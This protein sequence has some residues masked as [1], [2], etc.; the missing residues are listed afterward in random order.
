[1]A[2]LQFMREAFAANMRVPGTNELLSHAFR[3]PLRLNGRVKVGDPDAPNPARAPGAVLAKAA[4]RTAAWLGLED[5]ELTLALGVASVDQPLEPGS[6]AWYRALTL[7]HLGY[8]LERLCGDRTQAR[9]WMRGRNTSFGRPPVDMLA[10]PKGLDAL[11][12]HASG[13]TR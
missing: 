4:R 10:E 2:L 5:S 13:V 9:A 11:L 6:P 8:C 7:I 12:D 3:R 1:M